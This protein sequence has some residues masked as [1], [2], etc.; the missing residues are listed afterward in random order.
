MG[1]G[2]GESGSSSQNGISAEGSLRS[3][4]RR[5][6][7]ARK[8]LRPPAPDP[9]P[10]QIPP[11][12]ARSGPGPEAR[13]GHG[14]LPRPIPRTR[15]GTW[16]GR[17]RRAGRW[18]TG[19]T[20]TA[21]GAMRCPSA[22]SP[23]DRKAFAAH[24]TP[25]REGRTVNTL[26]SPGVDSTPIEPPWWLRILC[27]MASPSPVPSPFLLVVKND[28]ST[29]GRSSAAMPVPVS[30]T[31][32]SQRFP[33]G[34]ASSTSR[35]SSRR[36]SR[37]CIASQALLK[38]FMKTCTISL[39]RPRV[40]HR[41]PGMSRVSFTAVLRSLP[42]VSMDASRMAL[43]RSKGWGLASSLRAT[44]RSCPTSSSILLT[45]VSTI[46]RE[47]VSVAGSSSAGERVLSSSW[48]R[49]PARRIVLRGLAMSWTSDA[50]SSPT[51]GKSARVHQ[52]VVHGPSPNAR[53][54]GIENVRTNSPPSS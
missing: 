46:S 50:A 36:T 12:P 15:R 41:E 1:C 32:T 10:R 51:G 54:A 43:Q 28:S 6:R 19:R 38:R 42:L 2:P 18:H 48:S 29:W 34:V 27:T 9:L 17:R 40:R 49:V 39:S 52:P 16:P 33:S 4:P 11:T 13:A 30:L 14:A 3:T 23:R 5:R 24:S 44:L 37:P 8:A 21:R 31:R 47:E 45:A 7:I 26:P 22:P 20:G 35:P 25:A 53:R